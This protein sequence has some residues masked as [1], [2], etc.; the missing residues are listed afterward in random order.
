MKRVP[1][2]VDRDSKRHKREST[3]DTGYVSGTV[4]MKWPPVNNKY[5][6]KLETFS[7]VDGRKQFDAAFQGCCAEEF[8]RRGLEFK[9]GQELKLSL[10]GAVTEKSSTQGINLSIKLKYMEGVALEI[11]PKGKEPGITIDTWFQPPPIADEPAPTPSAPASTADDDWF[12]T[13]RA[14]RPQVPAAARTD[15]MDIDEESAPPSPPKNPVPRPSIAPEPTNPLNN[16]GNSLPSRQPAQNPSASLSDPRP[17]R[18][19]PPAPHI[20]RSPSLSTPKVNPPT[21]KDPPTDRVSAPPHR[22]VRPP[23]PAASGNHTSTSKLP[24]RTPT[25]PLIGYPNAP[26]PK[27]AGP[28][29]DPASG[30]HASTS[31]LPNRTPAGPVVEAI[32]PHNTRRSSESVSQAAPDP[33]TAEG[34]EKV[35]NKKQRKNQARKEKQKQRKAEAPLPGAPSVPTVATTSVDPP[36]VGPPVHSRP[37]TVVPAPSTLPVATHIPQSRQPQPSSPSVAEQNPPTPASPSRPEVPYTFTPISKLQANGSWIVYSII[38]VVTSITLVGKSIKGDWTCS[39]RVVDPSNCDES[40]RPSKEGLMVNCFA[41]TYKEWL[42]SANVG[43]VVVLRNV[44]TSLRNG[45]VVATGF[46]DKLQW[47][48]YD[49]TTR[50]IGHGKLGNAPESE[51][52][53]GGYGVKFTPFYIPTDADLTYCVALEGWWREVEARRLTAM[54]TIHQIGA[55][56]AEA[57][58]SSPGR[59][60]LLVSQLM[61]EIGIDGYFNCTVRVIHGHPNGRTHRLY[62]TD[63][64][65]F[66]GARPYQMSGCPASLVDCIMPIEMWDDAGRE[67]PNMLPGEYYI[68]N[69][70]RFMRDKQGYAESKLVEAKIQKLDSGA[71]DEYPTLKALL[72]RLRPLDDTD[73]VQDIELKLI[74]QAQDREFMSCLVELLHK[75]E[76]Q[77]AIYVT[78][79]TAHPKISAIKESWALGLD[80]HVLKIVLYDEQTAKIQHLVVGNYY[81]ILHLRLQSSSTAQEF[82][83]TLGG[84][85]NLIIAVNPKSSLVEERKEDLLLRKQKLK[86]QTEPGTKVIADSVV[87]LPQNRRNCLSIKQVLESTECPRTFVVRA[88]A[89]DFFP[90]K[91]N[92]SFER[93]CTKC[94]GLIPDKRLSCFGCNDVEC[95]YVKIISVFRL[96][97]VDDGGDILQLSVS[98][99][100]PLLDGLKCT[101]LRDDPEAARQFASRMRPLLGNLDAVH[102]GISMKEDIQPSSPKMTFIIDSW[103]GAENIVY[104]LRDYES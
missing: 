92:D 67:G 79:Y 33:Q 73:V 101:I 21:H 62:V 90:F 3:G 77:H 97:V 70:V 51:A 43:S 29:Q 94:N 74:G 60:H 19:M 28:P 12:A 55:P 37:P 26:P 84:S 20:V 10:K 6:F 68:L 82:R 44:K 31:K 85:D 65:P 48:V 11:L 42:P 50:K 104:G 54:G 59:K 96:A 71:A 7:L 47:A 36:D 2:E 86:D 41:K 88:R 66:E 69:N 39:L 102:D 83:G 22:I 100:I 34:P 89:V 30:S 93:T 81:T 14:P 15:L 17:V 27:V 45:D 76:N 25:V 103:E 80:G 52:L 95:K 49:P 40:Y 16:I 13:P 18:A 38:G 1:E 4:C 98:G 57:S 32:Q 99:N 8:R 9:M 53:A 63:G 58:F 78:D 72:E 64:T 5:R 56:S 46:Y 23:Q 24:D 35:L 75:D 87:S 61:A 91:L